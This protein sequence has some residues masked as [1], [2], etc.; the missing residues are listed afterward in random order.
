MNILQLDCSFTIFQILFRISGTKFLVM[1][2]EYDLSTV[3]EY[4]VMAG[5]HLSPSL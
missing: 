3:V 4:D 2:G 5:T 1:G